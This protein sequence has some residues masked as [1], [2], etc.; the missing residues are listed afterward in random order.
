MEHYFDLPVVYKGEE[1]NFKGRLATFGYVYK[2]YIVVDGREL[3]FERDDEQQYRVLTEE[4]DKG[5]PV[6]PELMQA[7]IAVLNSL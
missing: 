7:I 2:F 1:R 5:K 4:N 3:V 6:E